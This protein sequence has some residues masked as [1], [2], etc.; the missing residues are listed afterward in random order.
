[1]MLRRLNLHILGVMAG[2]CF[3]YCRGALF[4]RRGAAVCG[5]SLRKRTMH[6][7]FFPRHPKANAGILRFAR[8]S[9]DLGCQRRGRVLESTIDRENGD[10]TKGFRFQ[11]LRA[12]I[13]LVSEVKPGSDRVSCAIELLEDSLFVAEDPSTPHRV[14]ENK[15]YTAALTFNSKAVRNTLVAFIDI[16]FQYFN[17]EESLKLCFFASAPVGEEKFS[18]DILGRAQVDAKAHARC[19]VLGKLVTKQPLTRDELKICREVILDEYR[20]QYKK[21]KGGN[22]PALE[23]WMI[24]DFDRLLSRIEWTV[25]T[26]GNNE[27]EQEALRTIRSCHLFTHRH[28]GLEAFILASLMDEFEKRSESRKPVSRLVH[29][30][31]VKLIFLT[32]LGKGA[33]TRPMD[34]VH[35]AWES[36]EIS[37][38]RN[39]NEKI[40][41]VSTDYPKSVK[42]DHNLRVV[43]AKFE[44]DQWQREYV[45]LRLRVLTF[46]REL[47]EKKLPTLKLPLDSTAVDQIIEELVSTSMTRLESLGKVYHYHINDPEVVRGVILS[48]FDECYIAF[49]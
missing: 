20:D 4:H 23:K 39:L 48:L 17:D 37:D 35:K 7:A 19:N 3:R 34:P 38:L 49:D 8:Q 9:I 6:Y 41:A 36:V 11:K 22:L 18:A 42:D 44:A 16:D 30:A 25:T 14:E 32:A 45:S 33:P 47:L 31:D 29:A 26:D 21:R 40:D 43:M 27:L 1:M 15:N 5:R 28:E 2:G 10:K 12:C 13:R 46:C 24:K